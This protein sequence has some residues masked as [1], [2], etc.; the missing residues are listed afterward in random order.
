MNHAPNVTTGK[1]KVSGG[2]WRAPYGTVVSKDPTA[3]LP[4]TAVCLGFISDAGLVNDNS[5]SVST[6]KAWGGVIVYSSNEETTD[7]FQFAMIESEN[8]G[9]KKAVYGDDNVKINNGIVEVDVKADDPI[10]AVWIF[11]LALRN[12]KAKRIIVNDGAITE[13]EPINYNDSDAV[14][15][16]VTISAYPDSTGS[17]H[18]E[19]SEEAEPS[20]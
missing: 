9:V 7:T 8:V 5:I 12:G 20:V 11:E 19:Y 15:Y 14:A 6:I 17:T 10:H 13:R 4:G 16:G 18:H 2:I 1:P 3:A